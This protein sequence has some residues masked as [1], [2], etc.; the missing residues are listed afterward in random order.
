MSDNIRYYM[1]KIK[2]EKIFQGGN[3]GIYKSLEHGKMGNTKVGYKET[4]PNE[5]NI[6][7]C[8][9]CRKKRQVK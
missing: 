3:K 5:L 2:L 7:P 1:G 8:R 6:I 9:L 4:F